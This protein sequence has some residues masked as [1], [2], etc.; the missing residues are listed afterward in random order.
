MS[1]DEKLALVATDLR[2]LSRIGALASNLDEARQVMLA[3]VDSDVENLRERRG[4]GSY[5]WASLQREEA[6]RIKD[7]K[8]VERVQTEKELREVTVT[9]ANGY[10]VEVSVPTKRNLLSANNRVFVRNVRVDST[11]FDGRTTHQDIPV[12]VWVNPGDAT[13][14][15]LPEIGKS[16]HATAELGV[17]SGEKKAVATVSVLQAKLVD[18]PTSPYFPAVKRL[19]QV[20]E[21]TAARDINRGQLK[22]AV[23]E[24]LLTLPGELDKRAAE[25]AA[26]AERRKR[27]TAAGA[28]AV[29]DATPD[30]VAALQE[31][32]HLSSGTLEDQAAGRAKLQDLIK[33]LQPPPP[34]P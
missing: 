18:D 9:A 13:G 15:A 23:D 19:L 10:R 17:E 12:N 34:G 8:A 7:E 2:A 20:R 3:M 30:V 4:D 33:I 14:V 5:R 32:A 31:L 26:A 11:G 24:A 6:S 22:N 28:I 16:V 27:G 1:G 21:L 29:G 25:Q